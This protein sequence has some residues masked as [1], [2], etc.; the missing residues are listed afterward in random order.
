MATSIIPKPLDKT[1][2]DLQTVVDI[3]A[4]VS[5]NTGIITTNNMH[6]TKCGKLV[7]FQGEI[8]I[9]TS[10]L[11]KHLAT[12]PSDSVPGIKTS[13]PMGRYEGCTSEGSVGTDGKFYANIA[14]SDANKYIKINASWML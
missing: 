5:W 12:I 8:V 13:I 7:L 9:N 2:N 11:N 1:V 4:N 14:S 3:T 10:G 6:V